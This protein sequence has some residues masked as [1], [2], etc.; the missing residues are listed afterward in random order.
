MF[1]DLTCSSRKGKSIG[2][3]HYGFFG[4]LK[5]RSIVHRRG[6]NIIGLLYWPDTPCVKVCSALWFGLV[7]CLTNHL[8]FCLLCGMYIYSTSE[9]SSFLPHKALYSINNNPAIQ[10]KYNTPL[11]W[12]FFMSSDTF[13][14][15]TLSTFLWWYLVLLLV[16][17]LAPCCIMGL[18]LW[19][20][21]CFVSYTCTY[22]DQPQ[23]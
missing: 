16:D 8:M 23:H 17:F 20:G 9:Y 21:P 22:T 1:I 3:S 14:F 6:C 15:H 11:T 7:P 18:F 13:I 4:G 2:G 10:Y 19:V 12:T 5:H